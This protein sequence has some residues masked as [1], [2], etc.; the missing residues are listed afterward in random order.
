MRVDLQ[1]IYYGEA[2]NTLL[3]KTSYI[4]EERVWGLHGCST[5]EY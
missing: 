4:L 1:N 2:A 3:K 5:S